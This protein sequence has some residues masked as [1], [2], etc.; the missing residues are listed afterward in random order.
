MKRR[1]DDGGE[2]LEAAN[3]SEESMDIADSMGA[4]PKNTDAIK[5]GMREEKAAK[6]KAS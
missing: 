5:Y 2:I 4:G 1:Y 3:V 6:P